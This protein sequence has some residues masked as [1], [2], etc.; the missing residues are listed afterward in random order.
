MFNQHNFN[1]FILKHNIIGFFKEPLTLKSGRVSN[2]YVNWRNV[3]ENAFLTERLIEFVLDFVQEKNLQVDCF[4]GVPEGAT[5][6]GVLTQYT[7]A[8][9]QANYGEKIMHVLAM[10]RALPKAHGNPKDTYF[11]GLPQGKIIVLEDV[12]T[13]GLS[14]LETLNKLKETGI[15]VEA[16]VSLTNRNE[17]RDTGES[18]QQAIEQKGVRYFAM[19]NALDLLP[20]LIQQE[21]PEASLVQAVMEYFNKY[22]VH[23]LQL[24][25]SSRPHTNVQREQQSNIRNKVCIPLDNLETQEEVLARVEELK[26]IAGVFKIGKEAFTRFGP[27]LVRVIQEMGCK[28]F[29]D[30]KYHDIPNTVYKAAK[31]AAEL[32]VY[33]FTVHASGGSAMLKSAMEGAREGASKARLPVPRVVGV[34]ILTS[35]D[36]SILN[37]ELHIQGSVEDHVLHLA[38]VC[39]KAGL[40]G[41]VCSGGEL[42]KIKPYLPQEFLYITP[43][44]RL[45]VQESQDQKRVFTPGQAIRQGSSLL[46]VGR[47]ITGKPTIGEQVQAGYKVLKEIQ[48]HLQHY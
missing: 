18:V 8:K 39:Y 42:T 33:M 13:T 34:T 10:G 25:F 26:E 35:I 19:S 29:L 32:G 47:A 36:T 11:V 46:V 17:K 15:H 43:G 23:P 2:W 28:V 20:L 12:T 41:I 40:Q 31:A 45:H 27:S 4:Y 9:K 14:L 21:N 30:L 38:Q 16:V 22:G 44:I 48:E 37:Q 24:Q 3:T 7:W 6:L 5:K 1:Q